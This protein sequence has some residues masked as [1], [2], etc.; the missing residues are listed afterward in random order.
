MNAGGEEKEKQS[1]DTV[2]FYKLFAFADLTDYILMITCIVTA[3]GHGTCLPLM[4][5]LLGDLINSF[6]QNQ[7]NHNVVDVVSKVSVK[8][9]YLAV[10]CGATAF[11]RERQSA[12]I[13][14]LYLKTILRQDI[15]FFDK[16]T[17]T[18]EVVGRM[19]G[20]T[21]LIQDAIGEKVGKFTKLFSTFVGG[22][23]VAFVQGWLLTLLM[24]AL[25]PPVVISGSIMSIMIAKMASRGQDAYAKAATIVELTIGSIRTVAS[26]TGEKKA[27]TDYNKTLLDA[28]KSSVHEGLVAGL[29]LGTMTLLMFCSY[30]VALWY[31]AKMILERGYTGGDVLTIVFAVM[32]GSM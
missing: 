16:E 19:S 15:F 20:D 1:T 10:W 26:F 18:G 6:G 21:V 30:A 5:V 22:F 3:I 9:V 17:N 23:V 27:V 2:P 24:L 4:S 25:I 28:Y 7:N 11:L 13:R 29:G 14:N 8:F 32:T 31:G 12:R